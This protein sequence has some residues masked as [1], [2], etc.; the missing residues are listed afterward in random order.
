MCCIHSQMASRITDGS[1]TSSWA[2]FWNSCSVFSANCKSGPA[3]NSVQGLTDRFQG[4]RFSL[5]TQRESEPRYSMLKSL[6]T[7]H[8]VS[9]YLFYFLWK[10]SNL[11]IPHNIFCC[12]VDR[13]F[14]LLQVWTYLSYFQLV[15]LS[16]HPPASHWTWNMN[17][18]EF[19]PLHL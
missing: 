14:P 5:D 13:L 12:S 3:L 2:W 1:E 9:V 4:N 18:H 19:I 7:C 17:S 16:Q 8:C 15:V 10:S 11:Q 6:L